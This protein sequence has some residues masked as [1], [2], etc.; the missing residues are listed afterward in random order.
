MKNIELTEFENKS[1]LKA[2]AKI[3]NIAN[4]TLFSASISGNLSEIDF[5]EISINSSRKNELW[6]IGCFE[7]FVS[8]TGNSYAEYNFGFD[9]NWECFNFSDYRE[10]QSRPQV[11]IPPKITC[12]ITENL[13]TQTVEFEKD[14]ILQNSFSI[15]AVIKL[16]GGV[17][18][19]FANKHCGKKP[20]FH[21]KA[22]RVLQGKPYDFRG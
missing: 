10:N 1:R 15:T 11:N 7:I 19:Y 18:L 20:D 3:E 8:K 17:F 22:A 6:T 12:K 4:K 13:F 5:P 16:K 2:S 14:I 9:K 21:L